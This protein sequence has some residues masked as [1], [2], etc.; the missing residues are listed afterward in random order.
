MFIL[1]VQLAYQSFA[2]LTDLTNENKKSWAEKKIVTAKYMALTKQNVF[3]PVYLRL[4]WLQHY[5]LKLHFCFV[6]VLLVVCMKSVNATIYGNS[7]K[8]VC[9][10]WKYM[11]KYVFEYLPKGNVANIFKIFWFLYSVFF[12]FF[13]LIY[14]FYFEIISES[15][16]WMDNDTKICIIVSIAK[17]S[18]VFF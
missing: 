2:P 8:F 10:M 5:F 3:R 6:N 17:T 11:Y 12:F 7:D 16:L 14:C 9:S 1:Y 15:P 4:F 18:K 13:W